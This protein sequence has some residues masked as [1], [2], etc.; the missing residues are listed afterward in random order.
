MQPPKKTHLTK[1]LPNITGLRTDEQLHEF[2]QRH[3]RDTVRRGGR[4]RWGALAGGGHAQALA[5]CLH[6]VGDTMKHSNRYFN[7]SSAHTLPASSLL[8]LRCRC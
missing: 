7:T 6:M 1:I 4:G 5:V 2:L 3:K 8:P